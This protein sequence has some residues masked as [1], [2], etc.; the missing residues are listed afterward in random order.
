MAARV[1]AGVWAGV[2]AVSG[3]GEDPVAE[4]SVGQG[5]R[6]GGLEDAV[7]LFTIP[8][9]KGDALGCRP[10]KG[11]LVPHNPCLSGLREESKQGCWTPENGGHAH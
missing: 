6:G 9:G 8:L 2:R 11:S 4:F 10:W 5:R 7:C 1:P 3:L